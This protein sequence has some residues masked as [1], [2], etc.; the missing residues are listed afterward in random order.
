MHSDPDLK[1]QQFQI[2]S[3]LELLIRV[4]V[5]FLQELSIGEGSA[6][7][8]GQLAAL[9]DELRRTIGDRQPSSLEPVARSRRLFKLVGL[10]PTKDRPASEKLLRRVLA[11]RPF[12]RINDFVD[13]LNLVSLKL[14]FPL[15]FYD[16][17]PI[18]PPVLLRLGRPDEAFRGLGGEEVRLP[19]KIVLVDGEGPFGNPTRD[20]ERT[21][22]TTRTVRSLVVAFAPHDTPRVQME[23]VVREIGDAAREFCRGRVVASAI[24]PAR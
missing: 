8:S 17:H 4:G 1:A 6:A 13:A 10:D 5:V 2:S 16:W 22:V 15:G 12:P 18:V 19:G 9:G 7:L 21:Q 3:S 14:Q 24:L 11:S 20:S 23:E